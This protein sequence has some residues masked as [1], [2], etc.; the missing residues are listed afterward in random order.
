MLINSFT[1]N[2]A[3]YPSRE[4]TPSPSLIVESNVVSQEP[5]KNNS[6][7]KIRFSNCNNE[8]EDVDV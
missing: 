5:S 6:P 3:S 8:K 4:A 2:S 7:V 1:A